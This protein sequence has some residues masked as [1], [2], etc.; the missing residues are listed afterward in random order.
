MRCQLGFFG[1][2]MLENLSRKCGQRAA[3]T[4]CQGDVPGDGVA[5]ELLDGEEEAESDRH[6]GDEAHERATQAEAP[7]RHAQPG[8]QHGGH[9]GHGQQGIGVAHHALAL[10]NAQGS[11]VHN[12]QRFDRTIH[13]H[14]PK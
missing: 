6:E 4:L 9:H 7:H 2:A 10:L 5:L 14:S 8:P 12:I 3:L 11:A 13:L 1:K